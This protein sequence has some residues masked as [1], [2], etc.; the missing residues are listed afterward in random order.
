MDEIT[1]RCAGLKLSSREDTE[2]AIHV[3][4]TEDGPVLIGKFCTRGE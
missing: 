1:N 2:V 4:L 3:Q